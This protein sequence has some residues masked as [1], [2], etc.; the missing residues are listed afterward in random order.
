LYNAEKWEA[1]AQPMTHPGASSLK[2][3]VS[4]NVEM[5]PV[6]ICI[7]KNIL[8]AIVFEY[9]IARFFSSTLPNR[10]AAFC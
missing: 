9:I 10:S 8:T 6:S 1:M 4:S 3:S 7:F 5:W 2:G